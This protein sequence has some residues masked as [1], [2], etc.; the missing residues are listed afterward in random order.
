[1]A[2]SEAGASSRWPLRVMIAIGVV[3][4]VALLRATIL[5]PDPVEVRVVAIEMGRV[6]ATVTN[7]KAGT[8]RAR[9]RSR[10]TAETGG[11]VV[12]ILHREGD[13]VAAGALLVRLNDASLRAQLELARQGVR[14]ASAGRVEAC[15]R[16]DRAGREL[17]RKQSL[18]D[19]AIVSED[20]LDALQFSY[21]AAKVA[22]EASQ[23]DL[24]RA[25]ANVVAAEAELEKTRIV[26][27]FDGVLAEVSSEVG[28]WVTPSPPMLTS[29]A[30]VDLIDPSSLY[31]SAPM[32]EV[33]SAHI[34]TGQSARI[35][36][37]SRPGESFSGRVVRVAPYVLDVETQNRTIEIEVEFETE[38]DA[39]AMLPGTSA[40]VEIVLEA[41]EGVPR[42][43][44][45]AL[46]EG[47]RVLTLED[48]ELV[49]HR[50]SLGLRNW[51]YAQLEGGL[52]PGARVVTSL[53]RIE[54]KEGARAVEAPASA[55]DDR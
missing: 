12:E 10:V 52:E 38:E 18:A 19:E 22:C 49:E 30:V 53:D 15:L 47:D 46:L 29:P 9:R 41:H 54:V 44:T 42:L 13:R 33:D 2:A 55:Q 48:G 23:A 40:D 16:R 50:V 1:M 36:V 45:S 14:V 51:S 43:P 3:G 24:A 5:A 6:E 8:V 34:A 7:S 11:R 31:V 37:D 4:G 25:H 26:A 39:A 21:D 32:D 20:L 27:P 28:E 35:S 17:A